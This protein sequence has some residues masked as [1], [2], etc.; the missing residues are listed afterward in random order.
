MSAIPDSLSR[1]G[2]GNPLGGFYGFVRAH[3]M[4]VNALVLASGTLVA[5]LDFLAPKVSVLPRVVYS[6]TAALVALMILAAVIPALMTRAISALGYIARR[7]DL[8][9]LWRRPLWQLAVILLSVVTAAGYASLARAG[10]GG[11]LASAF[12]AVRQLQETALSIKAD[13][14]D[15]K[16]GVDAANS[17]LDVLV[18]TV[19]PAKAADRCADIDCAMEQGASAKTILKLFERGAKLPP[20]AANR[21][22]LAALAVASERDDRLE[23]LDALV[24]HGLDPDMLFDFSVPRPASAPPSAGK[25]ALDALRMARYSDNSLAETTRVYPPTGDAALDA[26]TDLGKCIAASSGGVSLIELAMMRGDREL[27]RH[28]AE[29]GIGPLSRPLVCKWRARQQNGSSRIEFVKGAAVAR[30]S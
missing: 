11:A 13:T 9:P 17:K 29:K 24:A 15:I 25:L 21:G 23:V 28:L 22:V 10:Q 8:I 18:A 20:Y 2:G 3:V 19:D 26:W 4:V 6:T 5:L 14:A 1:E 7:D 12:P 16:T 27:S 30:A